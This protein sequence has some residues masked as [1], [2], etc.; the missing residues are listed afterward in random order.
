MCDNKEIIIEGKVKNVRFHNPQNGYTVIDFATNELKSKRLAVVANMATPPHNMQLRI[1]GQHTISPKYGPQFNARICEEI[2]PDDLHGIEK[3]LGGGLFKGIGPATA[4]KIVEHFGK[5]TIAILDNEPEKLY[6]VKKI[7][8]KVIGGFIEQWIKNK[9]LKEVMIFLKK[10]DISTNMAIKIYQFYGTDTIDI[11][12]TNPY[13]MTND[14][15]GIGFLS[16]DK[17]ALSMGYAYDSPERI[18]ATI[19]YNMENL[20]QEG[21]T[22]SIRSIIIDTTLEYLNNSNVSKDNHVSNTLV[23]SCID[24][25]I[26]KME[27]FVIESE[28][29]EENK[30]FIPKYYWAEKNI[31]DKLVML[32]KAKPRS[33][34]KRKI[35]IDEIEEMFNI[36]YNDQQRDA[37]KTA[38]KNNVMVLTG[39][40]GTGKTTVTKGI[41]KALQMMEL[42]IT[43]AA[44]TGKAAD[45]M[46]EVTGLQASTIH[47]LIGCKGS[48]DERSD[49]SLVA[50]KRINTD[51]LIVDESSM[52]NTVLM[53]TLLNMVSSTVKLIL[54]GDIDQLPCI[55]PGNILSDIIKSEEIPVVRLTEIYRQAKDSKIIT[56]AHGINNDIKIS[57]SNNKNDDLFFMRSEDDYEVINTIIDLMKNRLPKKY[58]LNPTDIQVLTPMRVGPLGTININKILQEALNPS[59]TIIIQGDNMFK[60]NDKVMQIKN[61]YDKEVFNGDTGTIIDIDVEEKIITVK[62]KEKEVLYEGFEMD[63]LMLAY[64]ITIHKSQGSEYPICII[65]MRM[66]H[67]TMLK[68]NLIYTAITRCKNLCVLIGEERAFHIGVNTLDNK[69]R[70]TNL[71]EQIINQKNNKVVVYG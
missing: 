35:K 43:C 67:Y 65:P 33:N 7:K 69:H 29:E 49:G 3:Y 26:A 61:N 12:S 47:R 4:K 16:C 62:F 8:K 23:D 48:D 71:D 20:A 44:P 18:C 40:P 31:A 57:L 66:A 50:N 19:T 30:L 46:S 39:G 53:N 6:E 1:T 32:S 59:R 45:K 54:I 36:S 70:K 22:Y 64:A 24:I 60:L 10:Y 27:L 15:E 58:K 28:N 63:E 34:I 56:T 5:D 9:E 17:I 55:G 38:L 14:I 13:R 37:I 41:I 52:I 2:M 25:M 68:R 11:I 42:D 21:N 51:V